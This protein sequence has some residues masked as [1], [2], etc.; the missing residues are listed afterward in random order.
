VLRQVAEVLDRWVIER[1][2]VRLVRRLPGP[3]QALEPPLPA[4]PITFNGARS[5]K[6]IQLTWT[7]RT[8]FQF[9]SPQ[10]SPWPENNLVCGHLFRAGPHWQAKPTVVLL[11]GWRAERQYRW[12]FPWLARCL[13]R[14]GINAAFFLL[15]MHGSRCPRSPGAPRDFIWPVAGCTR[16]AAAQALVET[17]ALLR[18]LAG[19]GSAPLGLW[20]FSLGGWLAGLL[21]CR[22][23]ALDFAVLYCPVARMHQAVLRLPFCAPIRADLEAVSPNP[24]MLDL[25]KLQPQVSRQRLLLVAGQHDLF[26]P[27]SEI[28]L[29]AQ[30]WGQPDLWQIAHGHI[31]AL[32]AP[33]VLIRVLGW[34]S[35]QAHASPGSAR[36]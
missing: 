10:P 8:A 20:G 1:A 26:V 4:Q 34:I 11:H 30:R 28:E 14:R 36:A 13:N 32:L 29:L 27:L 23:S 19:Q 33:V 6:A 18:W 22:T 5:P 21:A 25:T 9:S 2:T 16:A 12:Q 31:S 7:S 15:P 35:R 17:Q 3:A 24:E